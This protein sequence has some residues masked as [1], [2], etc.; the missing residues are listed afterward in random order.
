M[1]TRFRGLVCPAGLLRLQRSGQNTTTGSAAPSHASSESMHAYHARHV[2]HTRLSAASASLG[3]APPPSRIVRLSPAQWRSVPVRTLPLASSTLLHAPRFV[4]D[5]RH[6]QGCIVLLSTTSPPVSVHHPPSRRHR[7]TSIRS[8]RRV[9]VLLVELLPYLAN[10]DSIGWQHAVL[11]AVQVPPVYGRHKLARRKVHEH[12]GREVVLAYPVAK[13]KVRL[14]HGPQR[15]RY[16]LD[17]VR[18][19][20]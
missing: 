6:T 5:C 1:A 12:A 14:E 10:A 3:V 7:P 16:R 8:M 20:R 15:Q 13:L 2:T 19:A 18:Q 4:I 11:Q 9:L 17:K